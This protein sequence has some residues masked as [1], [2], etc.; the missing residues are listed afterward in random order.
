MMERVESLRVEVEEERSNSDKVRREA[1]MKAE[2]DRSS[3]NALRDQVT[4]LTSK[5]DD[6]RYV[7]YRII[8]LAV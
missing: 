6:M 7:S 3:I 2:Q 4:R 5:I 8:E 1:A